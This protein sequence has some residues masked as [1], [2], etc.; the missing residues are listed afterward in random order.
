[1]EKLTKLMADLMYKR[2]A[3]FMNKLAKHNI[4]FKM[5][6]YPDFCF[7]F[8]DVKEAFNSLHSN[9]FTEQDRAYFDNVIDSKKIREK[10]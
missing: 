9:L 1:M 6:Y 2:F 3:M 10:L 8:D 5:L 7:K 4:E